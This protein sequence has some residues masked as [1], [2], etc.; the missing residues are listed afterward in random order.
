MLLKE[1]TCN[2]GD[3]G[4]IPELG[5]TPGEGNGNPLQY[6]CLQNSG[7]ESDGIQSMGSQRLEHNWVTNTFT[8]F[9]HSNSVKAPLLTVFI[10]LR[11]PCFVHFHF[12]ENFFYFFMYSHG[13]S[14]HW[15]LQVEMLVRSIYIYQDV[16]QA[17]PR[18]SSLRLII[19]F[20]CPLK[21]LNIHHSIP[22]AVL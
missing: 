17:F 10:F 5:R 1:S 22:R 3:L 9:Y 4:L 8:F 12:N 14:H 19:L 13:F 6:S 21:L 18:L 2:T 11:T 15:G 20:K 16:L 7:Q